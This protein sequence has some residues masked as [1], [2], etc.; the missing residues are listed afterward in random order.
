MFAK[1]EK[2]NSLVT[3]MND[4]M[5]GSEVRV[6]AQALRTDNHLTPCLVQ[7][8]WSKSK[9][10]SKIKASVCLFLYTV[11]ILFHVEWCIRKL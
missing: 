2:N 4:E 7:V 8:S 11:G 10:K 3:L 5:K 9:S 1:E 6:S